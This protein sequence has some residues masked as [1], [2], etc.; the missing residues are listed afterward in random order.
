MQNVWQDIRHA[1][2]ALKKS[3]GMNAVAIVTLAVGIAVVSTMFSF[4]NSVFYRPLPYPNAERIVSLSSSGPKTYW[5][6]SSAPLEV[7][8]QVRHQA[9]SF[10]RVAAFREGGKV[11]ALRE[12]SKFVGVTAVDSSVLPLLQAHPERGRLI[13]TAE[14]RALTPVAL[15]SDSLWRNT[16]GA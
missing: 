7:V 10:E 3:P 4:V 11:L 1:L 8:E 6:Y 2:R 5:D 14:I 12:T 15:I 9:R 13:T 16:F